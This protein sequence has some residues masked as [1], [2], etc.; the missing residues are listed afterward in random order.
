MY[1]KANRGTVHTV[2]RGSLTEHFCPCGISSLN[3]RLLYK[4]QS[5]GHNVN[6]LFQSLLWV[7]PNRNSNWKLLL[8]SLQTERKH[9]G[10]TAAFSGQNREEV[11]MAMRMENQL[12][13]AQGAGILLPQ[14]DLAAKI[15]FFI[16][17]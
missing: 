2:Y 6:L 7:M 13:S 16:H 4:K 14:C 9:E 12:T 15:F 5:A 3:N 17:F 8:E 1:H 11:P 10:I